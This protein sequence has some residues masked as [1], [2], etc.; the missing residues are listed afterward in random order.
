MLHSIERSV[1]AV[2]LAITHPRGRVV[3]ALTT[4][5]YLG[6]YLYAIGKLRFGSVGVDLIVASDPAGRFL[7]QSFGTFTYEP[8]V[9]VR[10]VLVTYQFSF[11][12]VLGLLL[13]GLVG[14]N[15]G[16]SYLAWHNPAACGIGS[17]SAGI[18]AGI[19]ALLSGAACCAPVIVLLVGIQLT[20]GLLM[21]FEALVPIAI[22][23][24]LG[25]LVLVGRKID[26]SAE[27]TPQEA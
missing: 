17:R 4:L 25:S 1:D 10:F 20:S 2:K 6:T 16:V 8:I 26:P 22:I 12:T 19:P 23:L 5:A 15:L 18:F 24:L 3:T 7:Q 11:N 21:L 14:V 9:L 27:H 13:A